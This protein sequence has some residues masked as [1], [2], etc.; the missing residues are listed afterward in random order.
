MLF[1]SGDCW[2]LSAL[3]AL[4]EF[5]VLIREGVFPEESRETNE[6]GCYSL[7]FCKM[8]LWQTVRVDDFFPCYPGGGPI[9]SR[10]NVCASHSCRCG[11]SGHA[12]DACPAKSGRPS[13]DSHARSAAARNSPANSR[14]AGESTTPFHPRWRPVSTAPNLVSTHFVAG[15]TFHAGTMDSRTSR[16]LKL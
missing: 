2:F 4:T 5:P 12:R 8:G 11:S 7:R 9:Y 15:A 6:Q 16:G 14:I 1:R 10:S 13:G 3:A